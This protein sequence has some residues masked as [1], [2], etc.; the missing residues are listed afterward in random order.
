MKDKISGDI[1][2]AMKSRDTSWLST[3][4]MI[5]AEIQRKE[6][7]KGIAVDDDAVVQILQSMARKHKDAIEQFR[8]GGRDDLADKE[9]AE[10]VI[11]QAYLPEQ[12]SED[13]IRAEAQN[14][15]A[16]VGA[17]GPKEMGKV[18]GVLVKKLAGKAD[19][20]TISRMVK[21]ELQKLQ[22]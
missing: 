18:M 20:G 21:E 9:Q 17:T 7:E 16:E 12:I 19:G 8:K 6:K 2:E 13:E 10:L 3:L 22:A 14:T 4:R 11:V 5:M 15:I 1:K